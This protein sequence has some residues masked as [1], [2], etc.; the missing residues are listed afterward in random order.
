M[1]V[2]VNGVQNK[3]AFVLWS[4]RRQRMSDQVCF[5]WKFR[6]M[7]VQLPMTGALSQ[8]SFEK[9]GLRYIGPLPPL[10]HPSSPPPSLKKWVILVFFKMHRRLESFS[11][12][13]HLLFC[14]FKKLSWI[15]VQNAR[16]DGDL[17]YPRDNVSSATG[18]LTGD[19][20]CPL[21]TLS[22]WPSPSPQ[23]SYLSLFLH[24]AFLHTDFSPHKSRTKTA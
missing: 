15:S 19:I 7:R 16:G 20:G 9:S 11:S 2:Q 24:R 12:F 3:L 21:F 10:N 14:F 23:T 1:I 4:W 18:A 6:T 8:L 22:S 5:A 13:S 17:F